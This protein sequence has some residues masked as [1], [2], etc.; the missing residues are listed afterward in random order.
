MF[1]FSICVRFHVFS[2]KFNNNDANNQYREKPINY[3]NFSMEIT[4]KL[5]DSMIS[6]ENN[7]KKTDDNV[8]L[9]YNGSGSLLF[10]F[11][12]NIGPAYIN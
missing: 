6:S 3:A 10:L 4:A 5:T 1:F 12:S 11:Y 7:E 8:E 2:F 9:N